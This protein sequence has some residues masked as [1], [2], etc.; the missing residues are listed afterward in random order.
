MRRREDG[1]TPE[2]EVV[3]GDGGAEGGGEAAAMAELSDHQLS[4]KIQRISKML[5]ARF[6]YRLPDRGAKL[7]SNFKQMQA[8][9]DRRK[10]VNHQK[11]V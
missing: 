10:L 4:D 8:E 5:S 3:P 6:H 11:K 1:T 9:L 2:V 7:L